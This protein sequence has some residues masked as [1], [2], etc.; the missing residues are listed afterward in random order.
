[1]SVLSLPWIFVL[2]I[3]LPVPQ[4]PASKS[5]LQ[6][7]LIQL[8]DQHEQTSHG[9]S[10]NSNSTYSMYHCWIFLLIMYLLT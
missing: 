4:R 6:G 3:V 5:P 9:L 7:T 2:A 10:H 8:S 1:M